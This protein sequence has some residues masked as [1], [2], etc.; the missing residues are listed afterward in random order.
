METVMQNPDD[1]I[2]NLILELEPYPRHRAPSH[3][4]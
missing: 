1:I 4:L 2:H 3:H